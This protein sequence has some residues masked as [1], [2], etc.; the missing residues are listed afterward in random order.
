MADV[1]ITTPDDAAPR[2]ARHLMDPNALEGPRDR[3]AAQRSFSNV[4]RWVMSVLAVST[5]LH[6][7]L[8]L[9]LATRIIDNPQ[10]GAAEMLCVLAGVFG[11]LA[12]VAGRM[13][14]GKSPLSWWLVLGAVPTL[15]GLWYIR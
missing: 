7:A 15:I 1:Q 10:P 9:I 12:V 14:H 3:V 4:Q 11:V 13:I 5:I 2:R 8:G 6:M